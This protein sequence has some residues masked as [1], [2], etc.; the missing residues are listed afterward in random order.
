VSG[1]LKAAKLKRDERAVFLGVTEL[2]YG[3]EGI[4]PSFV[5]LEASKERYDFR[6]KV[7]ANFPISVNIFVKLVKGV[8]E[9]EVSFCP[10][11][12]AGGDSG[13]ISA[14]IQNG[15]E[16]INCIEND[17]REHFWDWL[18]ESEL[19][20]LLSGIR[21]KID[22]SGPWLFAEELI[23]KRFEIADVMLCATG[24]K[25]RAVEQLT[26]DPKAG[27]DERCGVSES[28]KAFSEYPA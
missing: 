10:T 19:M 18:S 12:T 22:E 6:V 11:R 15:P 16:I 8:R 1:K 20:D 27:P 26:H 21:I 25:P 23:N 24:G 28:D 17:A 5:W 7:P 3:P 2:V 9:G 13:S 4:I 14:L